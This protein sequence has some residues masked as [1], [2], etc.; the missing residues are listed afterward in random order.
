MGPPGPARVE[1]GQ[2]GLALGQRWGGGGGGG[3]ET[4]RVSYS[5]PQVGGG[6]LM[7]V[8][9]M[10]TN[11]LSLSLSHWL[12]PCL[13]CPTRILSPPPTLHGGGLSNHHIYPGGGLPKDTQVLED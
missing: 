2:A 4:S 8:S 6:G 12:E 10:D 5:P 7:Y 1:E 13:R 3:E 9:Y 11:F